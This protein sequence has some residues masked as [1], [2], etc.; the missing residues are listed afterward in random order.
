MNVVLRPMYIPKHFEETRAD[1][2]QALMREHPLASLV[3]QTA[4]GLVADHIPLLWRADGSEHG[5]LVGHVARN[6]PLWQ[7]SCAT[8][9]LA[10]FQG[11][12][13]YISPQWYPTKRE[14]GKVVPTWN[15]VVVHVHGTLRAIDDPVWLRTLLG[16]LTQRHESGFAA[17]WKVED[18]PADYIQSMVQAVVGIE[19]PIRSLIGKCKTSQNQPPGNRAGVVQGLSGSTSAQA[20]EMGLIVAQTLQKNTP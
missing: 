4:A 3:T 1:V 18:A 11:P 16:E 2:L 17:P 19:I 20:R 8:E 13:A 14:H 7:L 12:Q 5:A 6:N 10:I 9:V 15:Y